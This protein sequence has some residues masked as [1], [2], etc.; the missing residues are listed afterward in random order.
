MLQDFYRFMTGEIT[1]TPGVAHLH[2]AKLTQVRTRPVIKP[3][4][5]SSCSTVEINYRMIDV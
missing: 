3:K 4:R 5:S 1:L 2:L